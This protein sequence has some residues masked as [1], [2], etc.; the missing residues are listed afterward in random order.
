M[1]GDGRQVRMGLST[2]EVEGQ[3][4]VPLDCP[5]SQA[6]WEVFLYPPRKITGLSHT[7]PLGLS[8]CIYK[9]KRCDPVILKLHCSFKYLIPT[10]G[11]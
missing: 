10:I 1:K 7:G 2:V 6:S 4:L 8:F 5:G 9:I 3:E 11:L